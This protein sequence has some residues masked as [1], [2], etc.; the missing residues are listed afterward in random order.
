MKKLFFFGLVILATLTFSSFKNADEP[1]VNLVSADGNPLPN[2]TIVNAEIKCAAQRWLIFFVKNTGGAKNIATL[3]RVRAQ[4]GHNQSELC[5]SQAIKNVPGILPGK[6][7]KIRVPLKTA[8]N[9]CDC[10]G[11]ICIDIDVDYNNNVVESNETDNH[12]T[13]SQ[14]TCN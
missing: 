7:F 13:V 8:G 11:N 12:L 6:T 14:G 1:Q 5:L 9:G 2:L 10:T 4:N 3:V